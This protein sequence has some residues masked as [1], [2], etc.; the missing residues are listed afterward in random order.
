MDEAKKEMTEELFW[1]EIRRFLM[2]IVRVIE[3]R[4]PGVTPKS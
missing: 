2:G 3:K 4:Y 1:S